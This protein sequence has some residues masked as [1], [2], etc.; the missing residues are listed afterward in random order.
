MKWLLL[1]QFTLFSLIALPSVELELTSNKSIIYLDNTKVTAPAPSENKV[2]PPLKLLSDS[3]SSTT[4]FK[5]ILTLTFQLPFHHDKRF[6]SLFSNS[7]FARSP[8]I[9]PIS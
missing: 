1:L 8:P 3:S 7:R 2:H 5:P 4:A 6:R 9:S